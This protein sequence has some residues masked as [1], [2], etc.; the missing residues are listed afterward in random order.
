MRMKWTHA[1]LTVIGMA[2]MSGAAA[3]AQ[4][5]GTAPAQ[6]D[7]VVTA[8]TDMALSFYKTF[9]SSSSG[10]GTEQTP[11]NS[12]G[13]M[14]EVRHISKPLLG[15][16]ITY[17]FNPAAQT[18]T[19]KAGACGYFCANQPIK[20]S[21]DASEFSVDYV[22]SK[23]YGSL[24]PFAVGGLGFFITVPTN[25]NYYLNTVVRIAYVYGGGV[26][27]AFSPHAGLRFQYRGNIY[28]AP[29]LSPAYNPTGVFTQT[30]EPMAG[31]YY[32]F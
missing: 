10:N 26:D 12:A 11:S 22:A 2:A 9:T 15:Y 20:T 32:S 3:L 24:R 27:W 23:K 7:K 28:K 19:P 14:F 18:F 8:Q 29:N 17:A 31:V 6:K 13:G 4:T 30:A 5:N 1:V 16:E 21:A 25:N